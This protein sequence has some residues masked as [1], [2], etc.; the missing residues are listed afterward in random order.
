MSF[1]CPIL[2][3][4]SVSQVRKEEPAQAGKKGER[5]TEKKVVHVSVADEE[6]GWEDSKVR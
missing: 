4:L 3:R 5:K 6:F 2:V 1:F